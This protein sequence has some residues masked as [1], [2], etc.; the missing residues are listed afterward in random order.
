M[1]IVESSTRQSVSLPARVSRQ[2]RVIA[3][4]KGLSSSKVI[5]D[6]VETGLAAREREKERF[7]ELADQLTKST[8]RNER[9]R[10]KSELARLTFGS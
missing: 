6:L 8:N 1:Q 10:I 7:F 5:A 9:K 2:V 3:K 4:S